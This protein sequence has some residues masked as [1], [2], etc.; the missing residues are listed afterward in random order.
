M[1][2]NTVA[3]Y[4]KPILY[5]F[6]DREAIVYKTGF[7]S[8]RLSYLDLYDDIYRMANWYQHN[9]L[10][11]GDII[12]LWA[13]NGPEWVAALLACALTGVVAVPLDMGVKP[14]FVQYIAK[15]TGAKA[16]IKSKFQP[17]LTEFKWWEIEELPYLLAEATPTFKEPEIH[18]NDTLEI[19]Y[20]S[21][22]TAEPKGVILTNK[23]IVANIKS[24]SEVLMLERN[25]RFL[26]VLPL[27]HMFEQTAGLFIPLFYGCS[28]TYLKTRKSSAILQAMQEEEI[29]SIIA[30]PLLL[31]TLQE[32]IQREAKSQG[33]EKLFHRMLN[34]AQH[35]PGWNRRI[36]FRSLHKKLG[37]NL[38][39]FAT[40]GAPIER[41]VEDFWNALGVKVCQG[42]GLTETSPIVTCNTIKR[43]KP[44]TVGKTLPNQQIKLSSLGEVLVKGDN[45]TQGYYKRPDLK[46]KYFENG[47][48]KT[49]DIGEIDKEGY[50]R[51]K[52]RVKNMILTA[53]GMN[54]YPEDIEAEINK[55]PAVK[56]SCVLG[57]KLEGKT[58]IQAVLLLEDKGANPEAIIENANDH[59]S[60]HQKIQTYSVW[61]KTD[62][63]RTTTLKIQRRFVL[64][65]LQKKTKEEEKGAIK[66]AKPLYHIIQ[67]VSG[68]PAGKIVPEAKLG[69]DLKIDS[70]RRVELVGV[71]EEELGVEIDE[72]LVTEK[73][74]VTDLEKHITS[75]KRTREYRV[76]SWPINKW[77]VFMRRLVQVGFVFPLLRI[78]VS[79]KV[80]GRE[81]FRGIKQ[82]F[83]LIANHTNFL[84]T[85]VLIRSLPWGVRR[86]LAVAAAADV[87]EQWDAR[88]A[89]LKER[90]LRRSATA[91]AILG[92]NIFPFQRYAG[93]KRSLEY[94]GKL[95]DKGWSVLIF[96]EG[97]HT[98][99][100]QIHEF[101]GGV[102]LLV[103]EMNVPV[104]PTKITGAYEIMDYRHYWPQR[105]GKITVRFGNPLIFSH[106]DSYEDTTK[107]LEHEVKFL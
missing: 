99:D 74:T 12:L 107:R 76:K 93:I 2:N 89:S 96:P 27:S 11:K 59:L 57:I 42:Y 60:D 81:K 54:V 10:Q 28:I 40:G 83:L 82:P 14:D 34:L 72:S 84:D 25:W 64:E 19:V 65:A 68:A 69:L 43:P 61:D 23:N 73:T 100:G 87:F 63:P 24:V 6:H 1:D 18:D 32:R 56:D 51:I 41:D 22:T 105:R 91:L 75:Q 79:L 58:L 4:F 49:G 92:L 7:R 78:Y 8:I 26:S 20:T 95:M 37:G 80:M 38:T 86:R 55:H 50:L 21:G 17:G 30:V 15:E 62:F 5:D 52:G 29:S 45:V 13:P 46:E 104:V 33:K 3:H 71:I 47:W 94:T 102:G 77:A 16:G 101:K 103:Q 53:S 48:Y 66:L 35:L 67:S 70:L 31:Q 9:G 88:Q 97:E 106:R 98:R 85:I 44:Y 39:F 90:M 36:L